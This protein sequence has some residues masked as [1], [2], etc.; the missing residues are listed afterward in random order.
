MKVCEPMSSPAVSVPTR[1]PLGQVAR[2]VAEYG[3]GS[4][5]APAR[6]PRRV[7]RAWPGCPSS[8]RLRG[9]TV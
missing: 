9:L 2:E 8:F 5:T 1:T 7:G 6:L 3:V 4:A